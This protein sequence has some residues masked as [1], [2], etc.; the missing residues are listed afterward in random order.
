MVKA[1]DLQDRF[2]AIKSLKDRDATFWTSLVFKKTSQ[3]SN[4]KHLRSK[5]TH[6]Y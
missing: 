6:N 3:L 4:L 2:C 1:G 5:T